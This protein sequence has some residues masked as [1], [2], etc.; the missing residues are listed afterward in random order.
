MATEDT[1]PNPAR[2]FNTAIKPTA[3]KDE[4]LDAK[5]QKQGYDFFKGIGQL[6]KSADMSSFDKYSSDSQAFNQNQQNLYQSAIMGISAGTAMA[7]AQ[8][9]SADPVETGAGT[10]APTSN[11]FAPQVGLD[12]DQ[13]EGQDGESE[14]TM[15]M[16]NSL[17]KL[18][19]ATEDLQKSQQPASSEQPLSAANAQNANQRG[20][21]QSNNLMEAYKSV[22]SLYEPMGGRAI[23]GSEGVRVKSDPYGRPY[24]TVRMTPTDSSGRSQ[25]QE[26]MSFGSI[27]RPEGEI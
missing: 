6:G 3:V 11:Y 17:L 26:T 22:Q 14:D 16:S 4:A 13:A 15:P 2:L 25:K 8:G 20:K 9:E 1:Q 24:T 27:R 19:W 23:A 18:K 10:S 21:Q 7:D 5:I 12:S